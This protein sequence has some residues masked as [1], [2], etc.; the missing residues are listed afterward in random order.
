MR[1]RAHGDQVATDAPK[2]EDEDE[3]LQE[4][5]DAGTEEAPCEIC[6][7]EWHV[8]GC[9]VGTVDELVHGIDVHGHCDEK[10]STTHR[11]PRRRDGE[12]EGEYLEEGGEKKTCV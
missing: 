5:V 2:E 3:Q 12:G 8:L 6:H 9:P 11:Q 10:Q 1:E 7:G 4:R